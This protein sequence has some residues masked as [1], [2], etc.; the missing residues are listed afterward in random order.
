MVPGGQGRKCSQ[1][2]E[3]APPDVVSS[4]GESRTSRVTRNGTAHEM[5]VKAVAVCLRFVCTASQDQ[6]RTVKA[7]GE[8]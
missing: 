1:T 5:G 6:G 3:P 2:S 7:D 8:R 4:S